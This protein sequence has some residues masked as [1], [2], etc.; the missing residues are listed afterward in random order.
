MV[1]LVAFLITTLINTLNIASYK[2]NVN[3]LNV[4]LTKFGYVS[5]HTIKTA[6]CSCTAGMSA[7]CNHVA[8]L[9]LRVEA[10]VR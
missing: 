8:A 9:L 5:D 3:H 10:A 1:G 6:H 2:L 7:T 4:P